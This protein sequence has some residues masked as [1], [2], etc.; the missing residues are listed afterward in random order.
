MPRPAGFT[1][2]DGDPTLTLM[3]ARRS[4]TNIIGGHVNVADAAAADLRDSA[5]ASLG[6]LDTL[7]Q[8]AYDPDALLEVGEYFLLRRTDVEDSFGVLAFLDRGPASDLLAP[9]EVARKPQLF[10]AA[11]IGAAP[12]ERLVFVA[13]SNPAKLVHAGFFLT[14]RGDVF[15][16]ID[17]DVFLFEDRVDLI[18]S[19]DSL[20]VLNQSAF[21]QWFR[22]T[23]VIQ[24]RV[25]AWING[26]TDHLPIAGDGADRLAERAR[27]DSRLRRTLFSIQA[28]GHLQHVGIERI[29]AHMAAQHLDEA[30]LLRGDELV[31]DQADPATLLKLLNEDLFLGG[32]TDEPFVVDRKSRR[33]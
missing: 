21:E 11:V 18:V 5:R 15:T 26:V 10:Y 12:A 7:E 31:F 2:R 22:D 1:L 28:R 14:L 25:H 6:D 24:E 20:V 4:G 30:K 19:R 17:S 3:V 33:H 16:K 32:L 23:P 8:R 29:R 9:E 13:K 27:T